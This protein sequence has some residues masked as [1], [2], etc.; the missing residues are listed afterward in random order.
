[1]SR[2]ALSRKL[3]GNDR[4]ELFDCGTAELN[5][6]LVRHALDNLLG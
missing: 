4:S 2:F 1:M 3:S 5:E 6:W